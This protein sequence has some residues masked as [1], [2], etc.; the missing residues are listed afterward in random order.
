ME[1]D[2]LNK[3]RQIRQKYILYYLLADSLFAA[4]IAVAGCVI[5]SLF[6]A[7]FLLFFIIL[8]VL[9]FSFLMIRHR[10]WLIGEKNVTAF[11]DSVYPELE[12]SSS[13]VLMQK[14]DLN[15]LQQLQLE[16]VVTALVH[17][18]SNHEHFTKPVRQ[19]AIL[20]I[21]A[22]IISFFASQVNYHWFTG[23]ATNT[24][25]NIPKKNNIKEVI[26]TEVESVE[27]V[28]RPPAYTHLQEYRQSKFTLEAQEGAVIDWKLTTNVAVKKISL[29]FNEKDNLPLKRQNNDNTKWEA[30]KILTKPGFYQVVIDGKSSDLYQ[31]QVINDLPPVIQIKTPKQYTYIDAGEKPQVIL[32]ATVT[33]DYGVS[34]AEIYATIAKGSGEAVKFKEQKIEFPTSFSQNERK[35][36]L[37]KTIDLQALNV[38]PGDELYFY[39]QARDN[40][41]RL[42]RTDVYIVTVQDTAQ[43][44]SMDGILSGTDIKPE[45]FR[46]ERQIILDAE[47]LLKEKDT[48]S[49][50]KFKDRSNEL[51]TDQKLLRLRYGKFLG[52]E[53]EGNIED[54][55]VAGNDKAVDPKDFGNGAKI[56]DEYTDKHD[57]AED[58]QFFDPKVKEQL[59]ATLT[60]MWKA[61]LQL[62]LYQPADALPF[63][64][65]AL[66]LL[67]DLQQKSRSFV[68]KTAYNPSPLKMEKRLSGDLDKII[69]PTEH[70]ELKPVED[71]FSS[72]KKAV[73]ILEQLSYTNNINSADRRL[74][75]EANQQLSEKAVLKSGAYLGAASAMR[76]IIAGNKKGL[77][78][79]IAI[80]E[81]AI[82]K[83]LPSS[84]VLPQSGSTTADMGLSQSYFLNFNH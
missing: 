68:A 51:G 54:P 83:I 23:N 49:Q 32:D 58:A 25:T 80:V 26:L 77:S 37:R 27:V 34:G 81:T 75:Q 14:A 6:F 61:E 55:R 84:E 36:N 5:L 59:K 82:R 46:S 4:A 30:K 9:I 20:L 19:S 16:K 45:Y 78:A 53:A 71:R 33:D 28:I 3:I 21:C 12:E 57:N 31:V 22:L 24:V 41:S 7:R 52:E 72:L 50:N 15:L 64:Y 62:R 10:Q 13:I 66:R 73:S 8:F 1:Y 60:E 56:L 29:L 18:P 76:R 79:N 48:L 2:A 11:L 43:L 69:Q 63:A 67:K 47:T 44:L 42:S 35:Y 38:E 65:K 70:R 40:N 74:L 39:V 17:I